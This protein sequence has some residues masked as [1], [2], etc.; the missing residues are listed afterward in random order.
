[1]EGNKKLSQQIKILSRHLSKEECQAKL[2]RQPN[3]NI[4]DTNLE[5]IVVTN[6]FMLRQ[7]F[8][9]STVEH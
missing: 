6:L 3:D 5:D 1:M 9:R 2:S 8:Q 7:I 4:E